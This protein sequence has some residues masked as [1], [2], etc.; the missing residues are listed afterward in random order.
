MALTDDFKSAMSG[1]ASGV[2]V[3]TTCADGLVYGLTVSSFS[4]VSLTP[5]IVSVCLAE[6]NRLG[7][8]IQRSGRLA[9]SVLERDQEGASN[10]FASRGREPS[11]ALEVPTRLTE[12]GLP[13]VEGALGW[14]V[15]DLYQAINVGDHL[16]VFGEVTEAGSAESGT[17]LIYWSRAY[18]S[19]DPA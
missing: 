4:S 18:R 19:V 3:V 10:H 9:I 14:L 7:E 13:I 6:S 8:L 12:D 1:W 17:P 5:P 11:E 2:S 15:C 16:V